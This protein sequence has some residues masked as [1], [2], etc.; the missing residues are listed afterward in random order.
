MKKICRISFLI[1]FFVSFN[2]FSQVHYPGPVD[3]T[4]N[5]EIVFDY[6]TDAC[7]IEDIPDGTA[8]AFRDIDGKIQL[9][10][11]HKIAYRMIGDNFNSLVRDCSNGPVFTSHNS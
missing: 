10:A 6:S 2:V 3:I 4:G 7:D 1:T 9:I 5:E 8:Q 11:S